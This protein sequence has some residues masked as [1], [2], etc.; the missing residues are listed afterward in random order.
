MCFVA[1]QECGVNEGG[2]QFPNHICPQNPSLEV[3]PKGLDQRMAN[4]GPQASFLFLQI[5]LYGNIATFI[6]LPI[7]YSC[8][9][10][11]TAELTICD[12]DHVD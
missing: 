1:L 7:V 3:C 6:S 5:K 9:C 4:Y 8:F 12:K 11:T 2:V 10:T